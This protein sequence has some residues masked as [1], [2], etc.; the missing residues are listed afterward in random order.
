MTF[1]I[2]FL[3]LLVLSAGALVATN[4][5]AQ[6]GN[7]DPEPNP[8]GWCPAPNYIVFGLD[9]DPV[10]DDEC[11][12]GY[13]IKPFCLGPEAPPTPINLLCSFR[14]S[15]FACEAWPQGAG[16]A[17]RWTSTLR[18]ARSTP[19]DAMKVVFCD[20][21]SAGTVK[22]TVV[23]PTSFHAEATTSVTVDCPNN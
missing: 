12:G 15:G 20:N 9:P 7:C 6:Q 23:S 8:A 1:S 18:T 22:V 5:Q 14:N 4:A 17:Y 13:R 10:T 2:R 21:A 16:L 11:E 19:F 3:A